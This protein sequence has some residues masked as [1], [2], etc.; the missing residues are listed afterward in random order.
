[1]PTFSA[2]LQLAHMAPNAVLR[3]LGDLH[4]RIQRQDVTDICQSTAEALHPLQ[5]KGSTEECL[6]VVRL[7][8]KHETETLTDAEKNAQPNTTREQGFGWEREE[9]TST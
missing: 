8:K 9:R 6:D 5:R 1:M 2:G 4:C 3:L 7:H